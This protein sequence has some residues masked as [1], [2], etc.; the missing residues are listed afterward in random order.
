MD[1]K[2][3]HVSI[4]E[5]DEECATCYVYTTKNVA[6]GYNF[7]LDLEATYNIHSKTLLFLNLGLLETKRSAYSY[8]SSEGTQFVE[9]GRL[10]N[11]P[12][13]TISTGFEANITKK[14]F[15]RYDI[16]AKDSF[17]WHD[18]EDEFAPS[19]T[20]H[21]INMRYRLNKK[22]YLTLWVKN[23]TDEMT[24]SHEYHF[25]LGEGLPEAEYE[26][27]IEPMTCGIKLD[28]KF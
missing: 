7:G 19:L 27:P 16:M 28:Y 26:S 14:L 11:A 12:G 24:A 17:L 3:I 1:R 6:S 20:L 22:T 10:A 18:D 8:E 2:N 25:S 23:L 15:L 9:E 13:W 21:N 5:Q 4:Q